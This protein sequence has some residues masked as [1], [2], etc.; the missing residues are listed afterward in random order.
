MDTREIIFLCVFYGRL[1]CYISYKF[2]HT[3]FFNIKKNVKT[4]A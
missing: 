4:Y 2:F 3:P 1:I